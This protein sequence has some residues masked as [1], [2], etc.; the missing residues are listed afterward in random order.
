MSFCPHSLCVCCCLFTFLLKKRRTWVVPH[1][2]RVSSSLGIKPSYTLQELLAFVRGKLCDIM[3]LSPFPVCVL[4]SVYFP[5]QK[6]KKKKVINNDYFGR[7]MSHR[8]TTIIKIEFV[9]WRIFFLNFFMF[10]WIYNFNKINILDM[11]L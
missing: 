4:L 2:L 5:S 3:P 7:N 6:K 11:N 9:F 1:R 8:L 10:N